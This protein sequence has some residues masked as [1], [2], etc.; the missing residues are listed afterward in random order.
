MT[1]TVDLLASAD[2]LVV[3]VPDWTDT[4]RTAIDAL[5]PP[6]RGPG[7][8][9]Q[10]VASV[11]AAV[12]T[13]AVE[14]I[15]CVVTAAEVDGVT[16]PEL[17]ETLTTAVE[18]APVVLATAD[19]SERLASAATAAGASDYVRLCRD[20]HTEDGAST[21]PPLDDLLDRVERRLR[22]ARRDVTRRR[23]A[24]QFDAI[25]HDTRTATW[26]L[27]P[28]GTVR[29]VNETALAA[30]DGSVS[31]VVG[32]KLWAREWW[33]DGG[34]T[35]GDGGQTRDGGGQTRSD[36]RTSTDVRD[37]VERAGD[38]E[39][40][41]LVVGFQPWDG[42]E[43]LLE[44]SIRPVTDGAGSV[45]AIVVE[46]VDVTDRVELERDLRASERLHRL[47]LNNMTDTVLM[48]DED[49][50]YTYVCP[51]AHFIFGYT[52]AEIEAMGS[53]EDLLGEDLFDPDELA[54]KEVLKNIECTA[55]DKAGREHTL[56]VNVRS[57]SVRDGEI[58][59]SCRDITKRKRREEALTTLQATA[60]ELLYAET[61]HEIA[62]QV[63][64]DTEAA[65]GVEA[66]GVFLFDET[67]NRLQL[68]ASDDRFETLHGPPPNVRVGDDGL[69]G[70]SFVTGETRF[71]D[72]V[73]DA[74]RLQNRATDLRSAAF[75]PL[76]DHGVAVVGSA[77]IG[78]FD[79][80][81]RELV[82]LFAAT[83]EAAL[84]RVT[85]ESRLR[86]QER[87]L[88]QQN[89][90]LSELNRV[91][92]TIREIDQA[93]VRAETRR[94]IEQT[95]CDRLTDGDRFAFAWIGRAD[96]AETAVE[97]R[98]WSGTGGDYLDS[99]SLAV[100]SEDGDPSTRAVR[101]GETVVV[102]D[103]AADL[104][105]E[106]WRREALA[107][108]FLSVVSLPLVYN[109]VV[110]GVL[111]VYGSV[112]GAFDETTR[113]VLGELRE[114]VASALAG[115]G[116]KNALVS[117]T[118][119]RTEYAIGDPTFAPTR[120]AREVARETATTGDPELTYRGRARQTDDGTEVFL[121]VDH[122][123]TEAV[124]AAADRLVMFGDV[125][126]VSE[127]GHGGVIRVRLAEP[128][129]ALG[130]ADHGAVLQSV[131]ATADGATVVVD[132]PDGVTVGEISDFVRTRFEDVSL[133]SKRELDRDVDYGVASEFLDTVT[134][135]QLEVA[136]TAYYA[137]FFESPRGSTGEEVA[138][139][140][141]ISSTAFYRHVRTVQ[142][143]LFDTLFD[144]ESAPSLRS[145]AVR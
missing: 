139:R 102:D 127:D 86:E 84:D 60:R 10:S 120:L 21:E 13:L 4:L 114:T 70:H 129:F 143:K 82:D 76:G 63:V 53:V 27:R 128:F 37:A 79:G 61:T 75:V 123:P 126:V 90:R 8:T 81:T 62:T 98:A 85:R 122:A 104:R 132:V 112:H 83:A 35:R 1:E 144:E 94:E 142:R 145:D 125:Q 135:R 115:I 33:S 80:V 136:Q 65:L 9:V 30:V 48:T 41:E 43:R 72:D 130:L 121:A 5:E 66:C 88:S 110:H 141:D 59:F 2:V 52:A 3:G 109:D 51:N 131:T 17:V 31:D 87:E 26:V 20:E 38:D 36:G 95:V 34:Q 116:R 119:V 11:D 71:F 28:D 18:T 55:T 106:T 19:G 12:E 39:Y 133:R 49:G 32:T 6:E 40:V 7:G 68:V 47:T 113:T 42:S 101:T 96:R 67:A 108:D 57:V 105:D 117:P 58:L 45:V 14:S 140:L 107:R 29:R 46:G 64:A 23:R 24:R 97:P 78:E 16:C 22:S 44:L 103:V 111:T 77:R 99:L 25:F 91:N 137:G 138:A 100:D 69:V 74:D 124:E 15:D 50:S 73:H 92:E 118:V 56:L 54:E 93:L 134:D 89:A